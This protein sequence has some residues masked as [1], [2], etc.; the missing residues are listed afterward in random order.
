MINATY[1]FRWLIGARAAEL[2]DLTPSA[3]SHRLAKLEA[4]LGRQLFFR[5]A[6][7]VTLTP[8]GEQYLT[9]VSGI[10]HS[11]AVAT[12]RAASDVS[13]DCRDCTRRPVSVCCGWEGGRCSAYLKLELSEHQV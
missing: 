1:A 4:M 9:E 2:L 7:G 8:V 3:V 13:L 6:R 10:L 12:E 11:L 5:T